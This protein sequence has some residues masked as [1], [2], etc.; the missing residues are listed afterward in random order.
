MKGIVPK[1]QSFGLG[2]FTC[3]KLV[4]EIGKLHLH[5]V[6][7]PDPQHKTASVVI[8]PNNPSAKIQAKPPGNISFFL[9]DDS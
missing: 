5:Q 2:T 8:R 6:L 4:M 9:I 3:T 1:S 7:K